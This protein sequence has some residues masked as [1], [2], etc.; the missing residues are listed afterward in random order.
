MKILIAGEG[1]VGFRITEE[2]MANHQIVYLASERYTGT[3]LERL[4]VETVLGDVTSPESLRQARVRTT[5]VFVACSDND[6]QNIVSCIAAQRLGAKRTICILRRPGFLSVGGDDAE[7]A[8]S[9]GIDLVIRP[10]EQLAEEI[11]RI[12]TVPGALDVEEFYDGRVRLLSY[13]VDE[14]SPITRGSLASLKLPKHVVLVM[15]RRGDEMIVPMG[16][17]VV[18]PGDRVIAMGRWRAIRWLLQRFLRSESR[19]K[20]RRTGTVVGGGNVGVQVVRGLEEAGWD[21][22]L[23]ESDRERCEEIASGLES[24][25]LHGDGADIDLLEQEHVGESSVLVATTDND[26]KNLLVSMMARQLGVKRIVTRADRLSNERL[27]EKVGIDVVRSARGAAIRSV[28]RTIDQAHSEI[29]AEIEHGDACVIE[30]KLPVDFPET[31]LRDLRPP[32]FSRV[33][34]VVHGRRVIVPGGN[35]VVTGG[36]E[37]L[38]FSTREDEERTREFYLNPSKYQRNGDRE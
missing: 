13:A 25:V 37:V 1:V 10:A 12:V 33:G 27:F 5:E 24:M 34:A 26:E 3:R 14:D 38:V 21:V 2:L 9:L 23:V 16:D 18:Q 6:E 11:I 7:L 17:T 8:D 35:D 4:D 20:D 15:L 30:L 31:R 32:T 36:D 29:R 22:K 19:G 28:V